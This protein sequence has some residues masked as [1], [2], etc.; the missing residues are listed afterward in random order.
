MQVLSTMTNYIMFE[1][2]T[3]ILFVA[4]HVI[5]FKNFQMIWSFFSAIVEFLVILSADLINSFK[6]RLDKFG[7]CMILYMI[8]ELSLL[9][10]EVQEIKFSYDRSYLRL[11]YQYS[12]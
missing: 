1:E 8:I 11:C 3:L 9:L 12:L 5:N 4:V 10:S 2:S 6:S 7:H